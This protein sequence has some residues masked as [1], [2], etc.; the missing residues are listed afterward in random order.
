MEVFDFGSF[1]KKG[2]GFAGQDPSAGPGDF[3]LLCRKIKEAFYREWES[4]E[5]SRSVLEL[6]KR[7]IIG[8]PK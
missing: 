5:S 6:Q 4:R 2:P 1:L 8:Y 7:A 3:A